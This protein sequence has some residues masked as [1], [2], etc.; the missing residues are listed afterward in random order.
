M[1]AVWLTSYYAYI[2]SYCILIISNVIS[3]TNNTYRKISN[4]NTALDIIMLHESSDRYKA[5]H[6]RRQKCKSEQT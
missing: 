2:L 5:G 1:Y 4:V 3:N 6:Q